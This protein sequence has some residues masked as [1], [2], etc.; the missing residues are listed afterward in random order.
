M[1][2][3]KKKKSTEFRAFFI[4]SYGGF[5]QTVRYRAAVTKKDNVNSNKTELLIFCA[6]SIALLLI[7]H[8]NNHG[9]LFFYFENKGSRLYIKSLPATRD[10][11]HLLHRRFR[12][13][14]VG[15]GCPV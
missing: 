4:G 1:V 11:L 10:F 3:V 2:T 14:C 12:G 8:V 7:G 6:H 13:S 9:S 5:K 15:E